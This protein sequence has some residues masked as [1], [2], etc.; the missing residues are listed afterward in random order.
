MQRAGERVRRQGGSIDAALFTP[1]PGQ[2]SSS[3]QTLLLM[4]HS[5]I[6][7]RRPSGDGMPQVARPPFC[8]QTVRVFPRRPTRNRAAPLL[9]GLETNSDF[10]SAAQVRL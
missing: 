6:A 1:T 2:K 3:I 5:A 10:P 9:V 8:S 4:F 7:R